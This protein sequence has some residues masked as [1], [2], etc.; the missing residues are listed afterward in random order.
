MEGLILL[1]IVFSING[2]IGYLIAK[3]KGR[4]VAGFWWGF[5][6]GIIGWIIAATL[7]PSQEV[8]TQQMADEAR[9]MAM[10]ARMVREMMK[11][12]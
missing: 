2:G 9:K 12:D 3:G 5:F 11:D 6:L 1:I 7:E 4:G 10:Q 8:K